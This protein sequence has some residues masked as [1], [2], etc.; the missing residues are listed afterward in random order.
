MMTEKE[1]PNYYAVIPA[2]VRYADDLSEFQ[3]LLYWEITALA[4]KDWYCYA[5]NNYFSSLYGKGKDWISKSIKKMEQLKYIKIEYDKE[6]WNVR[7]IFIWELVKLKGTIKAPIRE[8]SNRGYS[9]KLQHPIEE[10][11]NT[12]IGEN[13]N[14]NNI[15]NNNTSVIGED[16]TPTH[17]NIEYING[18]RSV[19]LK[20]K[21]YLWAW[22][23]LT[24][25]SSVMS[26]DVKKWIYNIQTSITADDFKAR[27]EKFAVIKDLIVRKNMQN[28]FYYRIWDWTLEDFLG[29]IN[30][31]YWEDS[32]I[33]SRLAKKEEI[34]K[35]LRVLE[36]QTTQQQP[37]SQ[38]KVEMTDE[39][40]QKALETMKQAKEKLYSLK[41]A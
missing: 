15:N 8:K 5:S 12:P 19:E 6:A 39:D 18:M 3:K 41:T 32:L 38:P 22:N 26:S 10:K 35:A 11:S 27:V 25:D 1:T 2:P 36:V 34:K 16:T 7:K 23:E 28:Y 14:H 24:W 13:S 4:Q 31:F 21:Q 37:V 9:R 30:K 29:N 33:I 17:K 40:K 20:G